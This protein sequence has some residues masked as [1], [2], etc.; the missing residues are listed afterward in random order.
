[1]E[2][3]KKKSLDGRRED[4]LSVILNGKSE[5]KMVRDKSDCFQTA[6][7][8]LLMS[9]TEGTKIPEKDSHLLNR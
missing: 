6:V 9:A 8:E 5:R 4:V 2:R 3:K 7:P 1:L